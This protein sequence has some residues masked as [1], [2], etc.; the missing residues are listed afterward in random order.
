MTATSIPGNCLGEI[1]QHVGQDR[2]GQALDC[3]HAQQAALQTLE[4]SEFIERRLVALGGGAQA[5]QQ[6][7]SRRRQHQSPP[8]PVEQR[9]AELVFEL[10]QLA[11][12]GRG[13]DV[14]A[15]GGRAH[16]AGLGYRHEIAVANGDQCGF[17]PGHEV[18]G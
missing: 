16:R 11:A 4:R 6:D 9:D 1:Q 18:T 12:D 7:G 17:L 10:D 3:R 14:E 8:R 2:D 5:A 15:A 13:R